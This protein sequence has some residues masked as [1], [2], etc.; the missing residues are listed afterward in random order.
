MNTTA[1][2]TRKAR[3]TATQI[4]RISL[5]IS[6]TAAIFYLSA[7]HIIEVA[8]RYGNEGLPSMVYPVSIDGVILICA[9]TLVATQNNVGKAAKRWAQFGR[10][11]GFAMTFYAN[12]EHSGYGSLAAIIINTA[13][14]IALIAMMETTI[15]SA[16][17]IARQAAAANRPA[18]VA[19][20]TPIRR[21]RPARR[22]AA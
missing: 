13:P 18:K 21:T 7:G 3:L 12:M 22:Q 16:K 4:A 2:T 6:V 11:F 17:T 20:V 19:S 5:I 14:A 15:H 1:N 9:I 8:A 10:W